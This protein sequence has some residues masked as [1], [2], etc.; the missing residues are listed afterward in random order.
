M[1]DWSK[2]RG[3]NYQPGYGCTGFENWLYFNP[4][5]IAKE[6]KN[7]KR[8]F[9]AMNTI[10]LWPDLYA[11]QLAPADFEKNFET[12]LKIC[13]SVGCRVVVALF[14]R[15]HDNVCDY[16]GIYFNHFLPGAGGVNDGHQKYADAYI[17]AIVGKHADDERIIAW[18]VC[19]E[20]FCYGDNKTVTDF[21]YPY[22]A[23]WLR[24]QY[25]KCKEAGAI[26]PV[27]FSPP[28]IN[29]GQIRE[30]DDI[31]DIY[32]IHPY[33]GY[34]DKDFET[35]TAD[36]CAGLLAETLEVAKETGKP[37]LTTE[38]CWG[39]W[40][41]DVRVKILKLTFEAHKKAGIGYIAHA[42]CYSRVADLHNAEDGP[43]GEPGNLCFICKDGSVRPG[44]D[45][46]NEY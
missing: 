2:I 26:Q 17:S 20:P 30:F 12:M 25:K 44:H 10:R 21:I 22:E 3:F 41:G 34:C 38:T 40:H 33:F 27:S 15:W 5:Q 28:R 36:D 18:D 39:S 32:M 29:I 19:N 37:V 35:L 9:P 24:T 31:S 6:L 45:I 46:F 43:T 8:L 13:D 11:F 42:L 1:T 23:E 16:G 7:G 14:N 4:E